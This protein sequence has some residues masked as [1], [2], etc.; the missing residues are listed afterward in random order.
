M[1]K[2]ESFRAVE[3]RAGAGRGDVRTVKKK[4]REQVHL[5][6]ASL[7]RV[8]EICIY[9]TDINSPFPDLQINILILL[10]SFLVTALISLVYCAQETT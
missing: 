2:S 3:G 6:K 4:N 7:L 8:S 5:K 1:R 10:P 9:T